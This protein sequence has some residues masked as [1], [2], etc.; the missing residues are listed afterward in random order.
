M[1]KLGQI[2]DACRILATPISAPKRLKVVLN[3][4]IFF[5]SKWNILLEL[6][7]VSL[8]YDKGKKFGLLTSVAAW[9]INFT[10]LVSNPSSPLGLRVNRPS[11]GH[12]FMCWGL[13]FISEED[14]HGWMV[15][16]W[17]IT[18]SLNCNLKLNWGISESGKGL[19]VKLTISGDV[20]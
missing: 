15:S 1:E 13:A 16:I 8:R 7:H 14:L 6:R 2:F 11:A 19:V 5:S 4:N 17:K 9:D 12:S 3:T 18:M 20:L 10:A